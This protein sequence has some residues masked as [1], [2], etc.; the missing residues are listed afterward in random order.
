MSSNRNWNVFYKKV[1]RL[2]S[3][4]YDVQCEFIYWGVVIKSINTYKRAEFSGVML[5]QLYD[6]IESYLKRNYKRRAVTIYV[7]RNKA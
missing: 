1:T 2:V 4:Y 6:N 3:Q 5:G 7:R